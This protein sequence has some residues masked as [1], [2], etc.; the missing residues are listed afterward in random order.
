MPHKNDHNQKEERKPTTNNQ[1]QQP[2][3]ERTGPRNHPW[4]Q[5]A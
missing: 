3:K 4:H 2:A 1:Q 5:E